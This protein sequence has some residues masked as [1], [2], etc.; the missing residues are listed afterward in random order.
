MGNNTN[1][2]QWSPVL[3]LNAPTGISAISCGGSHSLAATGSGLVWAWGRNAE[4]EVWDGTA[5]DR[6]T[7]VLVE[8][9]C[10]LAMDAQE[11][12]PSITVSLSPNPTSGALRIEGLDNADELKVLDALGRQILRTRVI[13]PVMVID[14]S[15]HP[16]GVYMVNVRSGSAMHTQRA[17][18]Q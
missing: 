15:C 7:P 3:V 14:L 12:A 4:H 17:V 9:V 2:D 11:V 1:V 18:K 5:I 16:V 8:E 6:W 10:A 13:S